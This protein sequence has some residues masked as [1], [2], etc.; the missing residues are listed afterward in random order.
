MKSGTFVEFERVLGLFSAMAVV[1]GAIIGVGIFFTPKDVAAIAGGQS[2]AMLAWT[3]GGLIALLGALTFAELGG[4]YHRTGAQYEILRDAYGPVVGFAYVF[5]NATAVQAGAIAIIAFISSQNLFVALGLDPDRIVIIAIALTMIGGLSVTNI[6]GVRWGAFAQNITVVAKLATIALIVGLA[7]F[8]ASGEQS[9]PQPSAAVSSAPWIGLLFA[10]VVP[11]LFSFGGWQQAL[12]VAGEVK[13]PAR[14]LPLAITGGVLVVIAAYLSVNWAYFRL[15]GFESVAKAPALAA[16]AVTSVWPTAG[17]RLVAAAVAFSALGVLNAQL[18]C[19]PRLIC[20]MAR[21]GRFFSIFG[22]LHRRFETPVAAIVLLG[23]IGSG[24][25]IA[26]GPDRVD[27]LLNGVVLV[28]SCGFLATGM[29]LIVL[30]IRRRDISW[31]FRTPWFPCVPLLFC[32]GET[33][34]ICGAFAVEKYRHSAAIG[35]AWIAAAVTCYLL[36]F[37]VRRPVSGA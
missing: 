6:L 29:A 33:G 1:I 24:L 9:L 3:V 7:I 36:F 20:G 5:C 32:L 2:L 8:L 25:L 37:R 17:R 13:N 10:A 16:D 22:R 23:A 27:Q 15:L 28:D 31:A 11:T 26:V 14:N 4:A 21:D 12:W 35:L 19:G 34:V 18:L 30:R